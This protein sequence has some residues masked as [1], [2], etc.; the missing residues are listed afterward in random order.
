MVATPVATPSETEPR[1]PTASES[2]MGSPSPRMRPIN[3]SDPTRSNGDSSSGDG[4]VSTPN[5]P[6]AACMLFPSPIFSRSLTPRKRHALRQVSAL[7]QEVA[8]LQ[9]LLQVSE[10]KVAMWEE[11]MQTL[12]NCVMLSPEMNDIYRDEC[13]KLLRATLGTVEQIQSVRYVDCSFPSVPTEA[14]HIQ[15]IRWESLQDSEWQLRW[16]PSWSIQVAVEGQQ[17][18]SFNLMLRL[19]D[20]R[21]SGRLKFRATP[22]LSTINISFLQMP[23]LRL[24]T[25]CTVSWGSVALPLQTY[26]EQVVQD[27]FQRW[28]RD[29]CVAPHE[30]VLQ[31]ASFQPKKGL[32]DA[33]VEKAI[34]AVTLAR[35]LSAAQSGAASYSSSFSPN[36][37]SS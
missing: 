16:A 18:L 23:K 21:V 19:F 20:F 10:A 15:L 25:E 28:T 4:E 1:S 33:D 22:D 35:E 27:E 5:L 37:G 32:T 6:V 29:N 13:T 11:C 2:S 8:R 12:V 9:L 14:P 36:Y 34:R 24:K 7:R 17:Y 31:P 3:V 26:I 30:M